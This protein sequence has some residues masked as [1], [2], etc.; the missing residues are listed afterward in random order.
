MGFLCYHKRVHLL[1]SYRWPSA[2]GHRLY[3]L[4]LI[5]GYL[6]FQLPAL[7]PNLYPSNVSISRRDTWVACMQAKN[8][9]ITTESPGHCIQSITYPTWDCVH[10]TYII[11]LS[12]A[13]DSTACPNHPSWNHRKSSSMVSPG[14]STIVSTQVSGRAH[15]GTNQLIFLMA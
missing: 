15:E 2:G 7:Y 1:I 14:L 6:Y 13:T 4:S 11:C 9:G 10:N 8:L 3:L 12:L 5:T